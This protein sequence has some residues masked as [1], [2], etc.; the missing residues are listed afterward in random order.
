M[1]P[2]DRKDFNFRKW[3]APARKA[4]AAFGRR[5]QPRL[6]GSGAPLIPFSKRS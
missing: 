1:D 4:G 6:P 5:R 2:V 3:V